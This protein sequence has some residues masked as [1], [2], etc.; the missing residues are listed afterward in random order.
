MEAITEIARQ[1]RLYGG[2][3]LTDHAWSRMTA[4]AIPAEV[5]DH[6]LSSGR[7]VHVRGVLI[8]A[9]GRREVA[10]AWE[11]GIDLRRCEGIQVVCA[12]DRRAVMTV[13]RNRDFRRSLRDRRRSRRRRS[14]WC[15]WETLQ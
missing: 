1:V 8:F 13:Y 2:Y 6:A 7:A 5:V 15:S 3:V 9:L 10:Q 14:G 11:Q 12:T 4:R